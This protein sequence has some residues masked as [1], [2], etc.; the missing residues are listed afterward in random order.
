MKG[1]DAAQRAFDN[2][3][4]PDE[5]ECPICGSDVVEDGGGAICTECDWYAEPD[6][7]IDPEDEPEPEYEDDLIAKRRNG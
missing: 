5:E 3:E 7:F 4:P 6:D 1:F 2:M